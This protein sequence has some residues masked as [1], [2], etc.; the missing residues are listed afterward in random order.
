MLFALQ[1]QAQNFTER[2]NFL[3]GTAIGF[4]SNTSTISQST[5][6]GDGPESF[7][8]NIAPHVGYFLFENF[9]IGVGLD[10]T[11]S[12]EQQPN[13]DKNDDTDL[14]FGPFG[15]YYI[16]F[17]GDKA[18]FLEGNFGFGTSS[19]DLIINGEPQS[20]ST[21]IIAFGAGP[22]FTIFSNDAIGIETL[23]KYNY[24][25]SRFNTTQDGVV[26]E[27]TTKTNQ[28]AVSLGIQVYF[29]GLRR[30]K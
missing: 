15:R 23:F 20:I 2:G 17:G 30:A 10:Y 18:V 14:L 16:P 26:T 19:D 12:R 21:D 22:G 8:W 25:R 1:I 13:E 27:T 6:K 3:V 24:A 9:A 7:Q 4:S 11:F 5:G 29:A 28:F